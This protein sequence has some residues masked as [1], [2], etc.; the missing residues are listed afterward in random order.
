MGWDSVAQ[1]KS[2]ICRKPP[3]SSRR[4]A[5][6]C[7]AGDRMCFVFPLVA[8]GP[9]SHAL[10]LQQSLFQNPSRPSMELWLLGSV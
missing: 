3:H 1:P 10:L 8:K 6:S 4:E 7:E 5:L 2:M 9:L